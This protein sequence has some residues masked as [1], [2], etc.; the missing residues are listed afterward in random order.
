MQEE[1]Q[2][3]LELMECGPW[4]TTAT[5]VSLGV[6]WPRGLH[7]LRTLCCYR[8][9]L[10]LLPAHLSSSKNCMKTLRRLSSPTLGSV[11]GIHNNSA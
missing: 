5:W 6:A 1:R 7:V 9:L 8:V 3:A 10:C 11:S 2:M 4:L